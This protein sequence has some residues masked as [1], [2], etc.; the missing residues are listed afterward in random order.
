MGWPIIKTKLLYCFLVGFLTLTLSGITVFAEEV[1]IL[2]QEEINIEELKQVTVVVESVRV[3]ENESKK[4]EGSYSA[5]ERKSSGTGIIVDDRHILT[6]YHI[7]RNTMKPCKADRCSN[8]IKVKSSSIKFNRYV[9]VVKF[10]IQNDLALL[11]I[12]NINP[13]TTFK[14]Q[15]L[16]FAESLK[17]NDHIIIVGNPFIDR[18][19]EI[20][21]VTEGNLNSLDLVGAKK[22]ILL[23]I[24]VVRGNSGSGV[25]DSEGKLIGMIYAQKISR[26]TGE[27]LGAMMITKE[28][29]Q[30]FIEGELSEV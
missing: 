14:V 29:M 18:Y 6:N 16:E 26:E 4:V 25:I 9:R 17:L 3:L 21:K 5:I 30:E 8:E 28:T 2:T 22:S 1:N 13:I 10:D 20:S 24:T 12:V 23:D 19:M 15:P 11:E 7:V 27:Y